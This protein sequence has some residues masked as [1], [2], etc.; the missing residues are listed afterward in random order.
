[1]FLGFLVDLLYC[2]RCGDDCM[3]EFPSTPANEETAS[4]VVKVEL[5]PLPP[6]PPLTFELIR[7]P[8]AAE[9]ECDNSFEGF[10]DGYDD[11]RLPETI[12]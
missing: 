12:I 4:K 8:L 5:P 10:V 3:M 9:Q 1:M 11:P 7:N 6:L 2:R